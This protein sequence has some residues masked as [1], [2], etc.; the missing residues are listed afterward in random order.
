[1]PPLPITSVFADLPDPRRETANK[2]HRLADILAIAT[3]A[4][5]GGAESPS[6]RH[7]SAG[8][9][10]YH[11]LGTRLHLPQNDLIHL[12]QPSES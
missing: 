3:C 10:R 4:V 8:R 6:L 12:D 5:I 2:L 7:R 9:E 1:M 11:N